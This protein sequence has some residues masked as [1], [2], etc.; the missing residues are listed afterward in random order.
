MSPFLLIDG[1]NVMYA[2]GFGRAEY[3]AGDLQRGRE[4]LLKHLSTRLT[5]AEVS[6][7][8][9]VFDARDPPV[10]RPA[11]C[12]LHG[13]TIVFAMPSGDADE[14]LTEL[15]Q[16]RAGSQAL[17]L[18]SGDRELQRAARARRAKWLDS[19]DFLRQIEKRQSSATTPAEPRGKFQGLS[20]AEVAHWASEFGEIIIPEDALVIPDP[21]PPNPRSTSRKAATPANDS[22][23][24]KPTQGK[25]GKP[26]RRRGKSKAKQPLPES[27]RDQRGMDP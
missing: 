26:T 23:S 12:V 11:R 19:H 8:L 18:V 15:M 5:A 24:F 4:Q 17:T 2:A 1:Y 27:R 6:R 7:S 16:S 13:I 3:A 9:V 14:V 22:A 20:A 25:S 10:G 21:E